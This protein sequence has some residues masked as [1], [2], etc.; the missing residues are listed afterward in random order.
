MKKYE[1]EKRNQSAIN[2]HYGRNKS[3]LIFDQPNL[4]ELEKGESMIDELKNLKL[5]NSH[6][7]EEN[8]KLK[9]Y[10]YVSEKRERK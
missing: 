9:E 2:L 10:S 7:L 6:L 4:T 8:K 5:A 3:E 1:E